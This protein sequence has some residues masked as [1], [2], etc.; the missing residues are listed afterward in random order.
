MP[1]DNAHTHPARV[2]IRRD[3]NDVSIDSAQTTWRAALA[4]EAATR[5]P[6]RQHRALVHVAGNRHL[7]VADRQLFVFPNLSAS[8]DIEIARDVAVRIAG[9]INAPPV[10]F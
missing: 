6:L 1:V 4:I 8:D 9:M 2:R 10:R 7:V 5:S 3:R